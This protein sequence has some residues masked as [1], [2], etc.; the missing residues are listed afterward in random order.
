MRELRS[1]NKIHDAMCF[2]LFLNPL[3]EVVEDDDRDIF[4]DIVQAHSINT[5]EVTEIE[6]DE[7]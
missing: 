3:E 1:M 4:A 2:S 7:E 6:A 5:V